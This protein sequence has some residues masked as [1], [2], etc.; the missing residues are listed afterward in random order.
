MSIG[1]G[2]AQSIQSTVQSFAPSFL[3]TSMAFNVIVGGAGAIA[4]GAA[5]Y[6][7]YQNLALGIVGVTVALLLFVNLMA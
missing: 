6:M 4:A 3:E 5:Y 7:L 2:L 1:Q